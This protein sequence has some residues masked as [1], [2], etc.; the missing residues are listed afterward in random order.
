[1]ASDIS[2]D[3]LTAEIRNIY[4]ADRDN[5]ADRMEKYLEA[6]LADRSPALRSVFLTELISVFSQDTQASVP[7]VETQS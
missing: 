7:I 2:L 3:R 5:G 6:A 4:Q 1:M